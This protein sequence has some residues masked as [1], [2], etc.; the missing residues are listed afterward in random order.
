MDH[1]QPRRTIL[2]MSTSKRKARILVIDDEPSLTQTFAAILKGAGYEVA[3]ASSGEDA[4]IRAA[5]FTPDLLLSDIHMGTMGMNGIEAANRIAATLPNCRVL[6][7]S[8]H[9]SPSDLPTAVAAGVEHR[10]AAKPMAPL[11]LLKTIDDILSAPVAVESPVVLAVEPEAF[12]RDAIVSAL[13]RAGFVIREARTGAE[14]LA[15]LHAKYD[16]VILGVAL[17]DVAGFEVHRA[18]RSLSVEE[19]PVF[20]VAPPYS[21]LDEVKREAM[22]LGAVEVFAHP[23]DPGDL[24]AVLSRALEARKV[25]QARPANLPSVAGALIGD[26]RN[27]PAELR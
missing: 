4:I 23:I 17:P 3:T 6:F 18:M 5:E 7:I 25:A 20:Y 8:G 12:A 15:A 13:T 21:P 26:C 1:R 16:A 14:A 22:A 27:N 19:P 24:I 11:A 10:F 9:L 2:K